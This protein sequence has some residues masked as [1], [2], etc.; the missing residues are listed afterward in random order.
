VAVL[1]KNWISVKESLL[2]SFFL[3]RKLTVTFGAELWAYRL[4]LIFCPE[5]TYV[6][7]WSLCDS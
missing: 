5:R 3:V 6:A 4:P 1:R 2:Q 7:V